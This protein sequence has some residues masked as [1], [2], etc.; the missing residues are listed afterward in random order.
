[1]H[2]LLLLVGHGGHLDGGIDDASDALGPNIINYFRRNTNLPC[3]IYLLHSILIVT[4]QVQEL[5]ENA[6][7]LTLLPPSQICCG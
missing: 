7:N 2:A 6:P 5:L 4:S 3:G 1:L